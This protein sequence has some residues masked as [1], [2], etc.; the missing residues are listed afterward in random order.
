MLAQLASPETEG[1]SLPLSFRRSADNRGMDLAS[2]E[3]VQSCTGELEASWCT[4]DEIVK[5]YF[6]AIVI[7]MVAW[8]VANW[9]AL[10]QL[11]RGSG[12]LL[13]GLVAK[14]AGMIYRSECYVMDVVTTK[15]MSTKLGV[16]E[17]VSWPHL[18]RSTTGSACGH[19][20]KSNLACSHAR[21][22][23]LS[24]RFALG[25]SGHIPGLHTSTLWF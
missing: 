21:L 3:A 20:V 1:L 7:C 19:P 5:A 16:Y 15:G 13:T 9:I 25:S 14:I 24:L 17:P 12:F 6:S 8:K 4:G 2:G 10:V 22:L 11:P 23:A 18:S